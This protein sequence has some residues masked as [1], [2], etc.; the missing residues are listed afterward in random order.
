[1]LEGEGGD[2]AELEAELMDPARRL[3]RG[4]RSAPFD[5]HHED[6]A[7][8][9]AQIR[10]QYNARVSEHAA[11]VEAWRTQTQTRKSELEDEIDAYQHGTPNTGKTTTQ[12]TNEPA[13]TQ[14][15]TSNTGG[16]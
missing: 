15:N 16:N 8:L 5:T 10:T 3:P 2:T 11:A 7:E 13:N 9:Q 4:T 14:T 12:T 1:M 6:S